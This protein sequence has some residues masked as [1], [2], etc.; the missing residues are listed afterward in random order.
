M[1]TISVPV[2]SSLNW[3]THAHPETGRGPQALINRQFADRADIVIAVF[4]RRLGSPTGKAA[5][6]TVEEIERARRRGKKVM[7]YFSKREAPGKMA[8]APR[9]RSRMARFK[10]DLG[11]NA[12]FGEY[13]DLRELE[14]VVRKDLALVIR[15][16]VSPAGV[17]Q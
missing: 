11:R 2:S 7:V 6:G 10:R 16:I 5:S 17:K 1:A 14:A 9:E 4:W 8:P 3:G 12:L 15:Q 13:A